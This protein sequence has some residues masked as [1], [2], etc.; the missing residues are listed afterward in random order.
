M[1]VGDIIRTSKYTMVKL[2]ESEA[3]A[4]GS[5]AAGA[6]Y[7][8]EGVSIPQP[9]GSSAYSSIGSILVQTDAA[10]ANGSDVTLRLWLGNENLPA[11]GGGAAG[12]CWFPAGTG[13][14]DAASLDTRGVLN[15]GNA[16]PELDGEIYHSEPVLYPGHF[17]KAYLEYVSGTLAPSID[18]WLL[19]PYVTQG[20]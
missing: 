16:I 10:S 1:P 14:V 3:A 4:N 13:A 2:L 7:A 15:E 17:D 5:P 11:S 9:E 18:A 6:G 8:A 19:I 20:S 12:G